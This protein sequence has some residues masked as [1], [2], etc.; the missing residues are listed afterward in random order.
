MSLAQCDECFL[1]AKYFLCVLL[2]FGRKKDF[3]CFICIAIKYFSLR[4]INSSEREVRRTKIIN[5]NA[6]CWKNK[7]IS[8]AFR[9]DDY[10]R[11]IINFITSLRPRCHVTLVSF[12]RVFNV[13]LVECLL[14]FHRWTAVQIRTHVSNFREY[15]GQINFI[16]IFFNKIRGRDTCIKILSF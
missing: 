7:I 10:L 16:R 14:S 8:G 6:L 2:F 5:D 9:C 15:Q 12:F 3:S 4:K 11:A 1:L 13:S